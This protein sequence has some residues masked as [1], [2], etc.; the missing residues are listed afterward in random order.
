MPRTA[1]ASQGGYC[2][3]VLKRGKGRAEVFHE[4]VDYLAFARLMWQA[5][6]RLLTAHVRRYHRHYGGVTRN[7]AGSRPAAS[8]LSSMTDFVDASPNNLQTQGLLSC[9]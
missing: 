6:E 5:C 3:H 4:D 7:Y 2:Y 8:G 1:R 9:S